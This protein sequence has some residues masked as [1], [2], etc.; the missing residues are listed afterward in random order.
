MRASV[1]TCSSLVGLVV[2]AGWTLSRSS[3]PPRKDWF[4]RLGGI[5][6][7]ALFFSIVCPVIIGPGPDGVFGTS[8]DETF[9]QQLIRPANLSVT[10]SAHSRVAQRRSLKD[11]WINAFVATGDHILASRTG[12]SFVPDRPLRR[13]THFQA[14]IST[15]SPPIAS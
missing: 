1:N 3:V 10:M 8:D 6:I 12:R 14:P 9:Q 15:H 5:G 11:L 13:L 7:L 2:L 4:H